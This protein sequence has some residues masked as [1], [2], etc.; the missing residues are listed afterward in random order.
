MIKKFVLDK[1]IV[2]NIESEGKDKEER[3]IDLIIDSATN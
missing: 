1:K 2:P 3:K